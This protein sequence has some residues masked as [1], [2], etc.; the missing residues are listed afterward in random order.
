MDRDIKAKY[1]YITV[2]KKNYLLR[3]IQMRKPI[4]L[5]NK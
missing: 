5:V 4:Y 3:N 2:R 1:N